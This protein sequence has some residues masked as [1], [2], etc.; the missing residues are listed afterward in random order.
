MKYTS[1]ILSS[2]MF[3]LLLGCSKEKSFETPTGGGPGGGGG[4]GGTSNKSG[5]SFTG[6]SASSY[7][8]CIDSAYFEVISGINTLTIEGTDSVDNTFTILVSGAAGPIKAGTYTVASGAGMILLTNSFQSYVSSTPTSFTLK[9]NTINDTSISGEFTA[10][11]V[12]PLDNSTFQITNGKFYALIGKANPCGSTGGGGGGGGGS[13]DAT[14][15]LESTGGEC[16]YFVEG[17][18]MKGVALTSANTVDLDVN[19]TKAGN[20]AVS[21]VTVNG[22]KFSGSGNFQGT[23]SETITLQGSGTPVQSGTF[24]LPVTVGT[25]ACGFEVE[26]E[27]V[28]TPSCT[29]DSNT[30]SLSGVATMTFPTGVSGQ[31]FGGNYRMT[32]NASNGDLRLEF[33]GPNRP[34]PGIYRIVPFSGSMLAGEVQISFTASSIFWQTNNATG[35]VFVT[36]NAAGKATATFCDVPFIGTLGGP[37]FNSTGSGKVTER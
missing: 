17:D 27:N 24:V 25:S 4:G 9:I 18:Y 8:G 36:V 22:I 2:L 21:T 30:A 33:A 11:L 35:N 37:S 7:Y 26:I 23:G 34:A 3:V 15:T 29:P 16:S 31:S 12:N 28:P 14:F 6:P 32:G 5:W 19:V 20:W 10:N 1:V 13:S